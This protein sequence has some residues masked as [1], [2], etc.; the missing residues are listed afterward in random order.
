MIATIR[1]NNFK[2]I[3]WAWIKYKIEKKAAFAIELSIDSWRNTI[4]RK[5]RTS[6]YLFFILCNFER[7]FEWTLTIK[8][9]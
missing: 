9:N 3:K 6:I 8:T 2:K 4:N 7:S 1:R 5:R